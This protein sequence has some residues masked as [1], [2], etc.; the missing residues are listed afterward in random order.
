MV[1]LPSI[2]KSI[3]IDSHIYADDTQ[4]WVSFRPEDELVARSRI[5]RAFKV[6]G[7][8]MTDNSL[9]LNADKTQFVPV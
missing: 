3:G 5:Q 9:Q 1:Q 2:L 4:F 6:I 8:F 7:K